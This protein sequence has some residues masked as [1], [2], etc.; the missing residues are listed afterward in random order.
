MSRTNRIL[1]AALG[2][3]LA[4]ASLADAQVWVRERAPLV[5]SVQQQNQR[6]WLGF[7]YSTN[8]QRTRDRTTTTVVIEQ[9]HDDSPAQAAGLLVGDTVTSINDI[10]VSEQL[11]N[12]LG[13]SLAPGDEVR[14]SVRR[15]GRDRTFTL[16][17]AER[18]AQ[19]ALPEPGT[20]VFELNADSIRD[21]MR[22]YMDSMRVTLD[23]LKLPRMRV[24]RTPEGVY[25]YSDTGRVRIVR[26]DTA[27]VGAWGVFPRDSLRNFF[28]YRFPRD[29]MRFMFDSAFARVLP[30][31][32]SLQIHVDSVR[33][34]V[35]SLN[36]LTPDRAGVWVG[37][38]GAI[39]IVGS[40]AIAGAEL[41]ELN[42]GLGEY[43][44]TEEGVLVVRVPD[45]TPAA[46]VGLMAGDV[47]INVNGN[48]IDD[49][50]SLRRRISQVRAGESI[51]LGILRKKQAR[52]IELKKE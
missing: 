10:R 22:I 5:V 6:G 39:A 47:V 46:R 38:P 40:R 2:L 30:D 45:G 21:R 42:P 9:V 48:A 27:W 52:T 3:T 7:S 37:S 31:M 20:F 35:D 36:W 11:M 12:S 17:A 51:R 23:S 19:F 8:T 28:E 44:G 1:T 43:F 4:A 25:I 18:P 29:S 24:E 26:P 41:T 16:T 13:Y 14:V 32:R 15:A 34:H 49:I 50:S 33:T